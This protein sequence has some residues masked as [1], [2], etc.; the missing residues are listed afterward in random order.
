MNCR[1]GVRAFISLSCHLS[2]IPQSCQMR[3]M[4][5]P[6]PNPL[7]LN[8]IASRPRAFVTLLRTGRWPKLPQLPKPVSFP[9][10]TA[11]SLQPLQQRKTDLPSIMTLTGVPIAPS[12]TVSIIGQYR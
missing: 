9:P 3:Q 1:T 8:H 2:Y 4:P 12:R 7:N 10:C 5:V 6:H 11:S